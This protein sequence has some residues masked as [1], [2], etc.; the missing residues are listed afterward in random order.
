MVLTIRVMKSR[1][2]DAMRVSLLLVAAIVSC[3]LEFGDGACSVADGEVKGWTGIVDSPLLQGQYN[4]P[5]DQDCSW[6]II[7]SNGS[8]VL[9]NFIDFDLEPAYDHVCYDYVE[10]YDGLQNPSDKIGQ[11]CGTNATINVRSSS[12]ILTIVFHSDGSQSFNGFQAEYSGLCSG[13]ELV[14][15]ND[16]VGRI[17]SPYYPD[18]YPTNA[19]C[20][21]L[22]TTGVGNKVDIRVLSMDLS[23]SS[24][25]EGDFLAVYN[26]R[27]SSGN[28]T[29]LYCGNDTTS[30]S[31]T[32]P[33]MYLVF[34]SDNTTNE[35]RTGF[36]LEYSSSAFIPCEY[37]PCLN[38]ATCTN[39]HLDFTCTCM[40]GFVGVL[41]EIDVDECENYPC[42]NGAVCLDG[43]NAYSCLCVP[44]YSGNDCEIDI[45]ECAVDPPPCENNGT[46]IDEINGFS[47][48]CTA[49]YKGPT[50]STLSSI[51]MCLAE[52]D[53]IQGSGIFWNQ[54]DG[55]EMGI[56][57]CPPGILGHAIRFCSLISWTPPI[58]EWDY[59]DLTNCVSPE[60]AQLRDKVESLETS[61]DTADNL[62]KVTSLL[63]SITMVTDD[64][65]HGLVK[66]LYPGDLL[67]SVDAMR[68]IA[69]TARGTNFLN[70]TIL[71]QA[72][73]DS[74]SNC[75]DPTTYI[76][77]KN[78]NDE[79]LVARSVTTMVNCTE[80]LAEAVA[81][82]R[83]REMRRERSRRDVTA[84]IRTD[85][86]S[87]G[88]TNLDFSVF[89]MEMENSSTD[90]IQA[91]MEDLIYGGS[92]SG[93]TGI[94]IP[95]QQLHLE[96]ILREDGFVG[97]F[98]AKFSTLGDLFSLFNNTDDVMM[99]TEELPH[100]SAGIVQTDYVNSDVMSAAVLGVD[101]PEHQRLARPVVIVF[102]HNTNV[103][104]KNPQCV[105][106]NM[107]ARTLSEQWRDEG[108]E[109]SDSN[110]THTICHCYHMTNFALIMDIHDIKDI[111]P[112]VHHDILSVIT[113]VGGTLSALACVLSICIF[114][115]FRLT[116]E[117]IRVHEN[118]AVAIGTTQIVFLVGI[119]KTD[120]EYVCKLVAAL[121]HYFLTALFLW[122]MIE[123]ISL[124]VALVKVF[125]RSNN[126]KKYMALGWGA[127]LLVVMVAVGIFYNEY[128]TGGS[129]WLPTE[130]LLVVFAPTATLVLFF[131]VFVLSVV[132]RIMSRTKT[133][134][135]K[136]QEFQLSPFKAGLKATL[137][138]FPL[139]GTSWVF[140][141]LSINTNTLLFTYMFVIL[142]SSQGLFFCVA[143]CILNPDVKN[144][145]KRRYGYGRTGRSSAQQHNSSSNP[146]TVSGH[147]HKSTEAKNYVAD[148]WSVRLTRVNA[149][150]SLADL[151]DSFDNP[152]VVQHDMVEHGH[153]E[154]IRS[155]NLQSHLADGLIVGDIDIHLN[156][157][158]N[159]SDVRGI[160]N[161]KS[162]REL[163]L[164]ETVLLREKK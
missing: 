30:S 26:G 68:T 8:I 140:G 118:L 108:C 60:F 57:P 64:E 143:H 58:A 136:R 121:L 85:R 86:V 55:D 11:Y 162:R 61:N 137:V 79:N 3:V 70:T 81:S 150:R 33:L 2:A 25:C 138:L 36:A 155:R 31:S 18:Y 90:S 112:V 77:W 100:D 67:I 49:D 164:S 132:I 53:D 27:N 107:Y 69:L 133:V 73:V 158:R 71:S 131:N 128:G 109:V 48:H 159:N 5:A 142:N 134:R 102:E 42:K 91:P 135:T 72:F 116:F 35:T 123:G 149:N 103:G 21:W 1:R 104:A 117:R 41:C 89:I 24:S 124:Y 106:M 6:T 12:N 154:E 147:L 129:C 163:Y 88:T 148:G 146:I 98:A 43:V 126:I 78:M 63:R 96:S 145:F 130:T 4:Y 44:G 52:I 50:C 10:L 115:Y 95:L 23:I 144:A 110:T 59:P 16:S 151:K 46:C 82:N 99:S 113:Y 40:P 56:E 122:M 7:V 157:A 119:D 47:C 66:Q 15:Y 83:A 111:I 39:Q 153:V 32:L 76:T 28:A 105:F 127:P 141:F 65:P 75:L 160:S 9:L 54:T 97:I 120:K 84:K 34:K 14:A 29:Q 161:K 22:I 152:V 156:S 62:L 87:V 13:I 114:E 80:L 74:V 125:D 101:L 17:E 37:E 93:H 139:L 45:D 94:T 19:S 92:T 38:N 51:P 20:D